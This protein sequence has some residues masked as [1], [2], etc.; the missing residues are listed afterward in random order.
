MEKDETGDGGWREGEDE[1]IERRWGRQRR[2]EGRKGVGERTRGETGRW[3]GKRAGTWL[4][5]Q[6]ESK[7]C[8]TVHA[9]SQRSTNTR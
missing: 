8:H 9:P 4:H 3:E 7:H 1:R 2:R 6:A 5:G